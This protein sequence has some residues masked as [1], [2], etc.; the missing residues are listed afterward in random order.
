MT[1]ETPEIRR[2]R[3]QM[4]SMRRGT[5]EMDLILGSYA[6]SRLVSMDRFALDLYEA[7][8]WESDQELY[9]W[10]MGQTHAP[11]RYSGLIEDII[12][13]VSVC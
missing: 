3:L 8:L 2:K 13:Q 5:K 12:A 4:R 1:G 9:S 11:G 7:L 10:I 6:A